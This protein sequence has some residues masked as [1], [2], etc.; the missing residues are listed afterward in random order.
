VQPS[1][2]VAAAWLTK[3]TEDAIGTEED[4]ELDV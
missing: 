1:C 3:Q 4:E 2:A